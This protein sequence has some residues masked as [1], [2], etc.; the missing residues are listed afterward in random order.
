MHSWSTERLAVPRASGSLVSPMARCSAGPFLRAGRTDFAQQPGCAGL[1]TGLAW[2][3]ALR[4]SPSLNA[5]N[6][7]N[8]EQLRPTI[9]HVKSLGALCLKKKEEQEHAVISCRSNPNGSS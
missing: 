8:R 5:E 3:P 2:C 1:T 6:G 7:W 9:A 4:I